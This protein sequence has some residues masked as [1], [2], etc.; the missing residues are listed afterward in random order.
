MKIHEYQAKKLLQEYS[1]PTPSGAV[2]LTPKEAQSI[3]QQLGSSLIVIKAQIHAGGR[4]KAGGV[5]ITHSLSEVE[6]AGT[7]LLGSTL[8]TKQT[9]SAG[10]KV[11]KILVEQGV[12]IAHEYYLSLTLNRQKA[13]N[14]FMASVEGGIEIEEIAQKNPE[15]IITYACSDEHEGLTIEQLQTMAKTLQFNT[16]T[17]SQ[18]FIRLMQQLYKLYREK[19]CSLIEINPLVLT[20]EKQLVALDVKMIFDDSALF[21]H[22]DIQAL[23]DLTEEDPLEVEAKKHALNYIKLTGNIGCMVNGAG[24]AMAT[25]DLLQTCGG[26]PANFLDVGGGTNVERVAHAFAILSADQDVQSIFVNIF[27]GIVRCDRVAEGIITALKNIQITVPI[28][29]RLAGTNCNPALQLL[30]RSGKKFTVVDSFEKAAQQ[31]VAMAK[32]YAS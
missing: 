10:K 19:D 25:M 16:A 11:L 8:V 22:P 9:G 3:A 29:I 14:T 17:V 23:R 20:K 24:L 7:A 27:G 18:Q 4:S 32:T 5:K 12:T 26:N 21:R 6:T 1:I 31:A 15:K 30:A 2:A 28:V 13:Q